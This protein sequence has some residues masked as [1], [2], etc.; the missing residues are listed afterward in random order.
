MVAAAVVTLPP[1]Q[2]AFA[3]AVPEPSAL[4][5]LL[6]FPFIVW[7]ADELHRF[8]ARSGALRHATRATPLPAR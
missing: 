4:A 5:L 2:A 8:V 6:P 7:G 3:T 1:L